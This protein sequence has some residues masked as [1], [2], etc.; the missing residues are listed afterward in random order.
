MDNSILLITSL[1]INLILAI[2]IVFVIIYVFNIKRRINKFLPTDKNINVEE[3]LS[4]YVNDVLKVLNKEYEIIEKINSNK[5]ELNNNLIQIKN[6]LQNNIN[7]TNEKIDQTKNQ[8]KGAL[9]KV[10]FVRY[11]PFEEVGGEL[12]YAIAFLDENNNGIV[13]NS[14]Y[15]RENCYSYAKD[16]TNGESLNYKLSAEEIKAIKMA[17]N[18]L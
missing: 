18:N 1:C 14:V 8:L 12:C 11:N 15:A 4:K 2:I 9:Q 7:L 6:E 10:G 17:M 13:I 5:N 16:I 3:M